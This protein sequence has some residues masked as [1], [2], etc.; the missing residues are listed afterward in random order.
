[1]IAELPE[2][3][4]LAPTSAVIAAYRNDIC[5]SGGIAIGTTEA[6]VASEYTQLAAAGITPYILIGM[7]EPT[8]TCD[9]RPFWTWAS[10]NYP[11]SR[12]INANLVAYAGTAST[13]LAADNVHPNTLGHSLIYASILSALNANAAPS[14]YQNYLAWNLANGV[15]PPATQL[16]VST[17]LN[18]G[19]NTNLNG[20]FTVGTC[21]SNPSTPGAVCPNQAKSGGSNIAT[22]SLLTN[23]AS[24]PNALQRS[25]R[26]IASK[27][28]DSAS[29]IP[30]MPLLP[31][32]NG[33]CRL[34][35]WG[36]QIRAFSVFSHSVEQ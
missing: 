16:S 12:V 19:N 20:L 18:V 33:S 11:A 4:A 8:G 15:L 7:Y 31:A 30:E 23:D 21:A 27:L 6:N 14:I 35:K 36:Q 29:S 26:H 25:S 28:I 24:V 5:S 17:N 13:V 32:A 22:F 10:A 2:L 1:M 3:I 9:Q 34:R